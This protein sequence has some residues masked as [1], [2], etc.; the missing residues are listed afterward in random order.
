MLSDYTEAYNNLKQALQI[1]LVGL[2]QDHIEVCDVYSNLGDVCMKL[3]VESDDPKKNGN[4]DKQS[5]LAEAKKYFTNARR[6]S[7]A[8]FGR[9]HTKTKQFES[10]LFIVENFNSF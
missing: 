1:L 2:G 4:D 3:L 6:I 7:E 8:T 5:K 10:L 9:E